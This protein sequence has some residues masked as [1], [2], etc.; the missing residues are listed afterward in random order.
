MPVN[1]TP[2]KIAGLKAVSDQRGVI[3]ALALDQRGLLVNMLAKEL[4]VPDPPEELMMEFKTLVAST[5]TQEASSILLDVEYGL[6]ASRNIH[7]KG[8]LLAYEK[9]G[10]SPKF[11]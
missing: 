7:G 3:A 8:L 9:S 6:N 10:Y 11:P 1:L 5:L 4:G 2:G